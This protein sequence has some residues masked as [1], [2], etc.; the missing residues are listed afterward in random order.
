M[1]LQGPAISALQVV[2]GRSLISA[3]APGLPLKPQTAT[4]AASVASSSRGPFSS[5]RSQQLGAHASSGG[6]ATGPSAASRIRWSIA[7]ANAGAGATS[8]S[9]DAAGITDGA[10][11]GG[12]VANAGPDGALR[13][14]LA[15]EEAA[16][17]MRDSLPFAMA[18]FGKLAEG[19]LGLN[20]AL[21]DEIP[22]GIEAASLLRQDAAIIGSSDPTKDDRHVRAV[23]G[24][25]H[26]V[27]AAG[28]TDD[29]HG[30]K[31]GSRVAAE[32]VLSDQPVDSLQVSAGTSQ[33][34]CQPRTDTHDV[35]IGDWLG[36]HGHT[37]PE[38]LTAAQPV[39]AAA[40]R[41]V[42]PAMRPLQPQAQP[43]YATGQIGV[44]THLA[45]EQQ[46]EAK[47]TQAAMPSPLRLYLH[48]RTPDEAPYLPLDDPSSPTAPPVAWPT[49]SAAHLAVAES[50]AAR[51]GMTPHS[52][53]RSSATSAL[54]QAGRG[55]AQHMPGMVQA[56]LTGTGRSGSVTGTGSI[57]FASAT[58]G[59]R[60]RMSTAAGRRGAAA[61]HAA[62]NASSGS[63][64]LGVASVMPDDPA[65]AFHRFAAAA[66]AE[67]EKLNAERRKEKEAADAA[68]AA[69]EAAAMAEF[70]AAAPL[71][72]DVSARSPLPTVAS[73]SAMQSG[74]PHARLATPS[75]PSRHPGAVT[76]Q[77]GE[78]AQGHAGSAA[79]AAPKHA[80][81]ART[82]ARPQ[83]Q[84]RAI[85]KPT[86]AVAAHSPVVFGASGGALSQTRTPPVTTAVSAAF[87]T[88]SAAVI[89]APAATEK[90]QRPV[91][92]AGLS[93]R[94]GPARVKPQLT[95]SQLDLSAFDGIKDLGQLLPQLAGMTVDDL[96]RN[97][98]IS[99]STASSGRPSGDP[100]AESSPATEAS[101]SATSGD[102]RAPF[103][104][105]TIG[106]KAASPAHAK[107]A[108]IV[109]R[110]PLS[111]ADLMALT[112]LAHDRALAARLAA[113][114]HDRARVLALKA[115][116]L[117]RLLQRMRGAV[118]VDPD[119]H[120]RF[121]RF[122]AE[123]GRVVSAQHSAAATLPWFS[124]MLEGLAAAQAIESTHPA[125]RYI[126][127][128]VQHELT[129]GRGI[130]AELIEQL[131]VALAVPDVL[132]RS[133]AAASAAR[134]TG[135]L[136]AADGRG[137][138]AAATA[139]AG[140]PRANTGAIFSVSS[141]AS[142][143]SRSAVGPMAAAVA[144]AHQLGDRIRARAA[145]TAVEKDAS[146][147][148]N[149]NQDAPSQTA[150]QSEAAGP[151]PQ[152]VQLAT[153]ISPSLEAGVD[154][155]ATL[156][157]GA[158]SAVDSGATG[159]A[160]TAPGAN[161]AAGPADSASGPSHAA[162]APRAS[163]VVVDSN[164]LLALASRAYA[165]PPVA[166]AGHQTGVGSGTTHTHPPR[167]DSLSGRRSGSLR[168][169][170]RTSGRRSSLASVSDH[171]DDASSASGTPYVSGR[172]GSTASARSGGE[173]SS[174]CRTVVSG[175]VSGRGGAAF[176][177]RDV[178]EPP[179]SVDAERAQKI[180]SPPASALVDVRAPLQQVPTAPL[181]TVQ[182]AA[183][184]AIE[185]A[186]L[187]RRLTSLQLLQV[188]LLVDPPL[189]VQHAGV[190]ALL[191]F[192]RRIAGIGLL[193]LDA[194]HARAGL[195][196]HAA[197]LELILQRAALERRAVLQ[198][199]QVQA[200]EQTSPTAGAGSAVAVA[201]ASSGP[202]LATIAAADS[203]S[204]TIGDAAHPL[205][206]PSSQPA[207]SGSS[208]LAKQQVPCR[209]YFGG[210]LS[211]FYFDARLLEAAAAAGVKP[212]VFISLE[213]EERL[214][215]NESSAVGQQSI[216]AAV[217]I[218]GKET[219]NT[220]AQLTDAHL[221]VPTSAAA[222]GEAS[223]ASS[224]R[225]PATP[226]PLL[227]ARLF[228]IA[229]S[230]DLRALDAD[231]AK[232][233]AADVAATA[234]EMAAAAAAARRE[235]RAAGTQAL[236]LAVELDRRLSQRLEKR[237]RSGGRRRQG[238][239][240]RVPGLLLDT[241]STES[242]RSRSMS[243]HA[244]VRQKDATTP[245][246]PPTRPRASSESASAEAAALQRRRAE[247]LQAR[248]AV[249][250]AGGKTVRFAD[251]AESRHHDAQADEAQASAEAV[252]AGYEGAHLGHGEAAETARSGASL[253]AAGLAMTSPGIATA[254][255][256][257]PLSK[258][259]KDE[260][261]AD[262]LIRTRP[263]LTGGPFSHSFHTAPPKRPSSN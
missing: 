217:S 247:A 124:A 105:G 1:S 177:G 109:S 34:L 159:D 208:Q 24:R 138:V 235:L 147:T 181:S 222:G 176:S 99:A 98:L 152:N 179:N 209:P 219:G 218:A 15:L 88:T 49:L 110:P 146:P 68:E 130:T 47:E 256:S 169:T 188:Q 119:E 262:L 244:G 215:G 184:Q 91:G 245:P 8:I 36:T 145:K 140:D 78:Q 242:R 9:S 227:P 2:S 151:L 28:A 200:R 255:A 70:T 233:A 230:G 223:A 252:A 100:A 75:S 168:I 251:D 144:S 133:S 224:V 231:A 164:M 115:A 108:A 258:T 111:V 37:A 30:N 13:D 263:S 101:A 73:A 64:P 55:T 12:R 71:T 134:A 153:V 21:L 163:G 202:P 16:A 5:S 35:G 167:S 114:S 85:A 243:A 63:Q 3:P 92:T 127:H 236:R 166:P 11:S 59:Q 254:A 58:S 186:A 239:A 41:P 50:R 216:G 196:P 253:S 194:M 45:E 44:A 74:D 248:A 93:R 185:A 234:A 117:D 150:P 23:G 155:A 149:T 82:A 191:A 173:G 56:S 214:M 27:V 240:L 190:Q 107:P 170:R 143:T 210:V 238:G 187:V 61:G 129:E 220:A 120:I 192:L 76:A 31:S 225:D 60:R 203:A 25:F 174:A 199:A 95:D 175:D 51:F 89:V 65:V 66:A 148:G 160:T 6:S 237:S 14:L 125:Q 135:L 201:A 26:F 67:R 10:S 161:E 139:A 205:G 48:M 228:S 178:E 206:L 171:H 42:S 103:P 96:R 241:S 137:G 249:S 195:L 20:L 86:P 43:E 38:S 80:R 154:S 158:S 46:V 183:A 257:Y 261:L 79:A 83:T 212:G 260:E 193:E 22:P 81:S 128:R 87:A 229:A 69:A 7:A 259:R 198:Q 39:A 52:R 29:A 106:N 90:S 54:A 32:A 197:S 156:S 104:A 165:P 142:A 221:A 162:S 172:R 97:L 141:F 211:S 4:G 157:S 84:R 62:T 112:R 113:M 122:D 232:R 213:L 118:A 204:P 246:A 17:S 102:I 132:A 226:H 94:L 126:V 131:L 33:L 40:D 57:G 207:A 77:A 189:L 182:S 72:L 121:L 53:R 180:S 136:S 18:A 19:G 123:A 250:A 116:A